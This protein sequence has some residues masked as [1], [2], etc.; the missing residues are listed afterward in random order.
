MRSLRVISPRSPS[1]RNRNAGPRAANAAAP[2]EIRRPVRHHE[3]ALPRD[4]A[5][6]RRASPP[7]RPASG[8][9]SRPP[10]S[11]SWARRYRA[12]PRG[13]RRGRRARSRRRRSG[14]RARCASA[15]RAR[16]LVGLR[17]G[18]IDL[19]DDGPLSAS[20]RNARA[21]SPAPR[22]TSCCGYARDDLVDGARAQLQVVD[23]PSRQAGR[24]SRAPERVKHRAEGLRHE[25]L[26]D[27]IDIRRGA[28]PRDNHGREAREPGVHAGD[29][30]KTAR[31]EFI[32][33]RE[34]GDWARAR[35]RARLTTD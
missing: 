29:E 16:T 1:P 32:P 17:G 33:G 27:G 35:A 2:A 20:R 28:R 24:Q 11:T 5:R 30:T 6:S 26:G 7:G 9:A 4:R 3:H 31:P 18:M 25:A 8:T 15:A 34:M 21:S 19:E 22:T 13:A 14:P 10:R 23:E 12:R